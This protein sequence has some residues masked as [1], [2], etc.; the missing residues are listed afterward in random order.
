MPGNV[1]LASLPPGL[2]HQRAVF[3]ADEFEKF[4]LRAGLRVDIDQV[5][6]AFVKRLYL[7][8]EVLFGVFGND[9]QPRL[10]RRQ[11]SAEAGDG[12]LLRK[13]GQRQVAR[14]VIAQIAARL[15]TCLLYTSR[16]V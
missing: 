5:F 3:L 12:F 4:P 11:P 7:V 16:C 14:D 2:H 6:A 15:Q 10:L 13:R 1:H 9:A 8:A